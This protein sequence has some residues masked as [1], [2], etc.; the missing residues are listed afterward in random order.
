MSTWPES[1]VQQLISDGK[2]KKSVGKNWDTNEKNV[3]DSEFRKFPNT[4][5]QNPVEWMPFYTSEDM[6][7]CLTKVITL[8]FNQTIVSHSCSK[9]RIL[10]SRTSSVSKSLQFL[11]VIHS[12]QHTGPS[13][14][15]MSVSPIC[16]LVI[17]ST[18]K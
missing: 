6:H 10:I 3:N 7:K 8:S 14:P 4:P 11:P 13:K 17:Q 2:M 5:G 18:R 12:D 15:K 9:N 1:S 16:P